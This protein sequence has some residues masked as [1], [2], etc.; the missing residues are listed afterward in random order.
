MG[1][2]K[3]S[4]G[5]PV[6]DGRLKGSPTQVPC[7][8]EGPGRYRSGPGVSGF[9]RET[10]HLFPRR[11][12]RSGGYGVL[13]KP[14]RRRGSAP[15]LYLSSVLNGVIEGVNFVCFAYPNVIDP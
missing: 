7:L 9:Q 6:F 11:A 15:N 13:P 10:L 12:I 5:N 4:S 2:I 3:S 1:E 8:L 14:L